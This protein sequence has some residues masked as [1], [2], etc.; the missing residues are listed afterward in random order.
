MAP[1]RDVPQLLSLP[2]I[3][4][5]WTAAL[6]LPPTAQLSNLRR[7]VRA[8]IIDHHPA[9]RPLS[10]AALCPLYLDL[11]LAYAFLG[12]YYL[13]YQVFK[14]AVENDP[15]SAVGWFGLGLAQAELG[16]WKNARR[17]WQ[18]C[19]QCFES[20]DGQQESIRYVLFQA[21]DEGAQDDAARML[22]VGL[23]C[24]EWTLERTRVEFNLRIALGEKGS[25]K[26]GVAPRS[27]G[28]RRPCLNGLSAG[29]RFGPGWDASLQCLASPLLGQYSGSHTTEPGGGAGFTSN[30]QPA[31]QT[32]PSSSTS[33][34]GFTLPPRVSSR[35]PLPALPL[36][37]P[38]SIPSLADDGSFNDHRPSLQEDPF[39]SSSE[40]E[41]ADP[42]STSSYTLTGRPYDEYH[43]RFSR[44]STLCTPENPCFYDHSDSDNDESRDT[45]SMIDDTI[46]SWTG[47]GQIQDEE[48]NVANEAREDPLQNDSELDGEILQPRVF[49]G[50]GPP[51]KER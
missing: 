14:E 42:F 16:E 19:L 41:V 8:I 50:F 22:E 43:E 30:L 29:L 36:S 13:A 28:Q 5:H 1:T 33:G 38:T 48:E 7:L 21:Q 9:L 11:A 15:T 2:A 37:P 34:P 46:A 17:S 4:A 51:N 10:I 32:P 12:E 31:V 35:K 24:G 39:T 23:N 3:H 45:S 18:A 20:V 6:S 25:K 40:E 49:E 26:L 27:A 44:Q 47:L